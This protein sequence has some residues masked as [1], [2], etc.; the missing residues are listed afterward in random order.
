MSMVFTNS[1]KKAMYEARYIGRTVRLTAPIE[2]P[3]GA[4]KPTG[5]RFKVEMIDDALQ[6]HG[7]WL[8]PETGSIAIDIEHDSFEVVSDEEN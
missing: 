4:S 3:Y 7:H 8:P 6:M 2:D 5:A 1:E